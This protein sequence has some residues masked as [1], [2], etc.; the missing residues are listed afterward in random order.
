MI[1]RAFELQIL[2]RERERE[3]ERERDRETDRREDISQE[4]DLEELN[5]KIKYRNKW[6]QRVLR[7]EKSRILNILFHYTPTGSRQKPSGEMEGRTVTSFG[8]KTDPNGTNPQH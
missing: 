1:L 5:V 3:R 7:M 4:I 2:G 8:I 6:L